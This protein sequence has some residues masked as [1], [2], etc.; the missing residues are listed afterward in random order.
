MGSK[1]QLREREEEEE[2]HHL[3][4]AYANNHYAGFWSGN[5]Q[6]I[7]ADGGLERGSMDMLKTAISEVT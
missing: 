5:C 7:Q 1:E 3:A 4:I 2:K 6:Y